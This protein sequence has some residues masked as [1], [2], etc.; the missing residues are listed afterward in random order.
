[1]EQKQTFGVRVHPTLLTGLETIVDRENK[2][3]P[4]QNITR[5]QIVER[6]IKRYIDYYNSWN[7]QL[8]EEK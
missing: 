8:L 4:N 2:K 5:S 3:Y 7:K 6:A 1:M